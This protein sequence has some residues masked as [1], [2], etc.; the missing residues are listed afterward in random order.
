M[1]RK[2][3]DQLPCGGG[4]P[5]AHGL[6]T[7]ARLG[8][9]AQSGGDVGRVMV[10]LI[11]DG[12]ANISLGRSNEDP[13]CIGPDAKKPGAEQLKD[14]VRDMAKKVYAA[15]LQLLVIDTENKFVSTGFAEEIAKAANGK[16]YYLP[17]ANDAAIAAAASSA[18]A[19]AKAGL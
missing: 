4:S 7:A 16:Y 17:N 13:D 3:L 15:G 12:R 14:E 5:L 6:S 2:R 18:M 10:V 11:T 8:I 19:A 1:A 9:Q